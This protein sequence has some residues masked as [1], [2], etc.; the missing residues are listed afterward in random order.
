MTKTTSAREDYV[1]LKRKELDDWNAEV[2][3]LEGKAQKSLRGVQDKHQKQLEVVRA[4]HKE[5]LTKLKAVKDA[6]ETTWEKLKGDTESV[7]VAFRD[8]IDQFKSHF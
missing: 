2:A 8:S 7:F 5:G 3:V 4:K 6:S 1:A